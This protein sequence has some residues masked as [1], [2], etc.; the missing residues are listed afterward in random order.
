MDVEIAS[1]VKNETWKLTDLPKRAKRIGV[2][3]IYK[4]KLNEFDQVAK[5]KARLFAKGY[6]Q[7]HGIDYTKVFALISNLD[8]I[9][10]VIALVAQKGW[11]LFQLDFK[12]AFLNDTLSEDAYVE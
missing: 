7:R 10:T 9:R 12:S 4:T 5:H 8:T 1:T 2:K 11:N 3:W 6:S